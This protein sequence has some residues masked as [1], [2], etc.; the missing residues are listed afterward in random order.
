M[1]KQ[2]L[3]LTKKAIDDARATGK[4]Y[5]IWDNEL[6]GFGLSVQKTGYK[7]YFLDYRNSFGTARRLKLAIVGEITPDEARKKAANLKL[8]I[9]QGI[10]PITDKQQQKKEPTL[11]EIAEE[12]IIKH[13]IPFKKT[14][15]VSADQGMIKMYLLP[16]FNKIKIVDI[17]RNDI[18][19][20]HYKLR[21]KKYTANRCIQLLSKIMNLC[22][23]WG[24]RQENSNPCRGIKKYK[25]E[26]RE[27]FLNLD[28]IKRLHKNLD[29]FLQNGESPYFVALIRLLLLTGARL[30]EILTCKWEY[31]NFERKVIELP[32][33]KTGK[34]EIILCDRCISILK[35]L[36][37]KPENPYVIISD[38]KKNHHLGK[39]KSNWARLL[40]ASNLN[41]LRIHDLRH[42]NASISL[43]AKI[44]IEIISKRLGH[45]N[46]STTMRYA[47]LADSQMRQATNDLSKTLGKAMGI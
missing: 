29:K 24:Y 27:R 38:R 6:P 15:S 23:E 40:I 12:Y 25:E 30:S 42:T 31:I 18:K 47:H 26:S 2:K 7:S 43:Q 3:K 32:D 5:Y 46:I 22:E 35:N 13:A 16:F 20:F 36:E 19:Q 4:R 45:S 44:P 33:S 34:K 41:G 39:P 37:I 9:S 28:E 1:S 14:T 21:E 10:D 11:S 8:Q 17:N